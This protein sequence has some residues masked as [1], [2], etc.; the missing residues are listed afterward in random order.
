MS[1]KKIRTFA[2]LVKIFQKSPIRGIFIIF[3]KKFFENFRQKTQKYGFFGS[4]CRKRNP[5]FTKINYFT[6][7]GL[8][9]LK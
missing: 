5:Y 2:F 1:K 9:L 6:K 3:D 7:I 8:T 4:L